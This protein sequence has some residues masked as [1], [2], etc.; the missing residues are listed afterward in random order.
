[1]TDSGATTLRPVHRETGESTVSSDRALELI[2]ARAYHLFESRGQQPGQELD[3]W[4]RAER[5]VLRPFRSL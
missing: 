3:D 1:M 5:E 4:L 2:R